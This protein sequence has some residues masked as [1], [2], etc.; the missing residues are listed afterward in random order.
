MASIDRSRCQTQLQ[1]LST[2][3][4]DYCKFPLSTTD[5]CLATLESLSFSTVLPTAAHA[6][7]SDTT[8]VFDFLIADPALFCTPNKRATNFFEFFL[9][10]PPSRQLHEI[11]LNEMKKNGKD[12]S[13]VRGYFSLC[14]PLDQMSYITP[15]LIHLAFQKPH[16]PFT[17]TQPVPCFS[18]CWGGG[19][20]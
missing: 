4:D 5:Y 10:W 8:R 17:L 20:R 18:N 9:S 7:N 1:E 6:L 19:G 13:Y 2:H 16:H 3:L 12:T 14:C 11:L 15:L